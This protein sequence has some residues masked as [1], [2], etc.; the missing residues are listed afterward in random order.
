VNRPPS[1]PRSPAVTPAPW[2]RNASSYAPPA[3]VAPISLKLDANEGAA[4]PPWLREVLTGLDAETFRRYPK[5]REFEAFLARRFDI[6]PSRVLVTAGGDEAIDRACRA[7]LGPGRELL[8]PVPTFEMFVRYAAVSGAAVTTIDWPGGPFPTDAVAARLSDRTSMVAVVSPNNPTGA[9]IDAAGL[10]RISSRALSGGAL[11]LADLAYTEFAD[12]DLTPL[13]LTLPNV[14]IVRTLSKAWGLAGLRIGYA[15]GPPDIIAWLRAAA[16]PYS[17]TGPSLAIARA[18]LERGHHAMQAS[19]AR[20]KLEVSELR[21]LLASLGVT[22][23]PSQG[24]FVLARFPD[25]DTVRAA[26]GLRGIAVRGFPKDPLLAGAL[27]ITVPCDAPA[28]TRLAA[29]LRE[30]LAPRPGATP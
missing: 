11:I 25:A 6:D 28:F 5:P 23:A 16:G 22:V 4:P 30:I 26:L 9:V 8:L 13:A 3:P 14:V 20:A 7:T 12:E 27:R 1:T 2:A 15:L 24:N 17:V 21:S 29:A 10:E 19:V 18:C